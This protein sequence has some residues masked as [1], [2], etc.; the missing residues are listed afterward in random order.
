[1]IA[2]S[3]EEWWLSDLIQQYQL[4][5]G[6]NTTQLGESLIGTLTS[7]A[8]GFAT[9]ML[10]SKTNFCTQIKEDMMLNDILLGLFFR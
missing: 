1:M 4:R 10:L 5:Q 9:A 6:M 8:G 2:M 7:L 3:T